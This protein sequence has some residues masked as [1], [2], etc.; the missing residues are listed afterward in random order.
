VHGRGGKPVAGAKIELRDVT[1]D[2]H[3]APT[4]DKSGVARCIVPTHVV[5]ALGLSELTPV[6]VKVDADGNCQGK[7]VVE[8]PPPDKVTVVLQ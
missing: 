6:S 5:N 2:V 7:V 3:P 8:D 4:T 1:G